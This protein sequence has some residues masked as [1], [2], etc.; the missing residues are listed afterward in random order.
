MTIT[1]QN[2]CQ[3]R[4]KRGSKFSLGSV[5]CIGEQKF[6]QC[7]FYQIEEFELIQN[8]TWPV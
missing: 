6:Y 4:F 2:T 7:L 5:D 3:K 8:R 1:A